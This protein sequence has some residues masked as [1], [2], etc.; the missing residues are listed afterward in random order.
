LF[1]SVFDE[2]EVD[3]EIGELINDKLVVF[4]EEDDEFD[5]KLNDSELFGCNK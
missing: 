3:V 4:D 2:N 1:A 5:D